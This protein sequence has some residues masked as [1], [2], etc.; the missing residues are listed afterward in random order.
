M[1][2]VVFN[3]NPSTINFEEIN[4]ESIVGIQW[5]SGVRTMI[6]CSQR[7]FMGVSDD[8]T[9]YAW[10]EVSKKAYI[11]KARKEGCS[12]YVFENYSELFKWMSE[13]DFF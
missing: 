9:R 6:V 1:K 12:V 3:S 5:Q 13:A 10:E 2:K 7:G 8:D 4:N 11:E